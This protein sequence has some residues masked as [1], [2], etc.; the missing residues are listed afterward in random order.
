MTI[1]V[2]NAAGTLAANIGPSDAAILLGAGQGAAFPSPTGGN[3]FYATL[4]H[5]ATGVI[6]IVKCTGR[7]VDTLTVERGRDSTSAT[8]FI[9]GSV[10]ECRLV[11]VMLVEIDY[12]LVAGQ[13]NGLATLDGAVKLPV[14]QL[15]TTVPLLTGG[16]LDLAVIPTA[17]PTAAQVDLKAPKADPTFTGT[18]TASKLVMSGTGRLID[19]GDDA[20]LYDINTAGHIGIKGQ[21]DP[22]IGYI[23]F[24]NAPGFG[25]N[26][27]ALVFNGGAVYHAGNFNPA[28]AVQKSGDH[29]SGDLYLDSGVLRLNSAG[30]RYL[31]NNG[32]VYELAGQGLSVGGVL[33]CTDMTIT[34]SDRRAKKNVAR[35]QPSLDLS[36]KL[37][38]YEWNLKESGEYG[39]GPMAQD[40]KRLAPGTVRKNGKVLGI[41][42][43]GAALEYAMSLELRVRELEKQLVALQKQMTR[44]LAPKARKRTKSE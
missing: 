24:G 37:K 41:D 34:V 42:K 5:F 35:V 3:Y 27:S 18:V 44:A 17:V 10:L 12:R 21:V 11:A 13:A 9:T 36:R 4:Q 43:A 33:Y 1:F 38:L 8:S 15:P 16:K 39:R 23:Q 29:M 30:N 20:A 19:V 6:E 2:N 14:A 25:W 28:A 31:Y 32:S 7:S 22:N 40:L 26:G